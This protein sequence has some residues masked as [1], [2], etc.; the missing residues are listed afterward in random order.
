MIL[1]MV[2]HDV[3]SKRGKDMELRMQMMMLE[4]MIAAYTMSTM[5]V[6]GTRPSEPPLEGLWK[7]KNGWETRSEA[8]TGPSLTLRYP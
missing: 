5:S 1:P 2:F 4:S 3:L 6:D 8:L 7:G